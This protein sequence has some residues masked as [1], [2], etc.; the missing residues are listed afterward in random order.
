MAKIKTDEYSVLGKTFAFPIKCSSNGVFYTDYP[1]DMRRYL[2]IKNA[3]PPKAELEQE[4]RS[5]VDQMNQ[6]AMVTEDII[7]YTNTIS[8]SDFGSSKHNIN[9]LSIGFRWIAV[10]KTICAQSVNYHRICR[11]DMSDRWLSEHYKDSIFC[12]GFRYERTY[13]RGN[14]I[15]E[16]QI[17]FSPEAVAFF[18][19]CE[20]MLTAINE[21]IEA[22]INPEALAGNIKGGTLILPYIA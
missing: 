7:F 14:L 4:I 19:Q 20:K 3:F 17:P 8:K 13:Y 11:H 12:P 2:S 9:S 1:M 5:A 22:F 10:R 18:E 16:K 15:K 21:R 6:L